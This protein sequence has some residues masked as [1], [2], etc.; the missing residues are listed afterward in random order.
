MLDGELM[1]FLVRLEQVRLYIL[2]LLIHR[3]LLYEGPKGTYHVVM[4]VSRSTVGQV[5]APQHQGVFDRV[6]VVIAA[7]TGNR[8]AK[9]LIEMS[10]NL[11]RPAHLQ[12]GPFRPKFRP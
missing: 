10:G 11:V 9:P 5:F 2:R 4:S 8:K 12:G 6:V 1:K 3:R 7:H